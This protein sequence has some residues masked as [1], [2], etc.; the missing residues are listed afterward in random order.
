MNEQDQRSFFLAIFG[1]PL[2]SIWLRVSYEDEKPEITI[3]MAALLDAMSTINP[4][5]LFLSVS[6]FALSNQADVQT[7][8]N[9]ILAKCQTSHLHWLFLEEIE[10][11]INYNKRDDDGPVGF[12]DPLLHASSQ[13]VLFRMTTR[14]QPA[15]SSLVS[16]N[17]VHAFFAANAGRL[18]DLHLCGLGLNNSHCLAIAVALQ[19]ADMEINELDLQL[20]PQINA[21][22]YDA[23]LSLVNRTDAC[24]IF[25][26]DDKTWEGELNLVSEMN[27]FHGRRKYMSDGAFTSGK[28][29]WQWLQELAILPNTNHEIINDW[30]AK[31]MNFIWYELVEHPEFMQ[32]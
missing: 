5:C 25:K 3:C 32:M 14:T 9:I 22:G 7:M 21:E 10:C 18:Q 2:S 4:H 15:Y 27:R 28:C 30:E 12:L 8:S 17:A 31:H 23:L 26:V 11:H 6:N 19:T 13:L 1:L 16:T 29:R 20:N 24:K